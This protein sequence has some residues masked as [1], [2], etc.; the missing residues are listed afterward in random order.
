MASMTTNN[1]SP[2]ATAAREAARD[3]GRFGEQT[4][5]APELGLDVHMTLMPEGA[6]RVMPVARTTHSYWYEDEALDLAGEIS[7]RHDVQ[8]MVTRM[9]LPEGTPDPAARYAVTLRSA[10]TGHAGWSFTYETG[11]QDFE[12]QTPTIAE[13]LTDYTFK[14]NRERGAV[15]DDGNSTALDKLI[16][17]LGEDDARELLADDYTRHSYDYR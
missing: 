4:H 13:V 17:V 5:T 2:L 11:D 3:H 16:G 14:A 6:T 8:G 7:E 1:I 15:T 12:A 9:P 10:H